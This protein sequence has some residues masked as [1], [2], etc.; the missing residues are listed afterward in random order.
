MWIVWGLRLRLI[1]CTWKYVQIKQNRGRQTKR[2]LVGAARKQ[3]RQATKPAHADNMW[4]ALEQRKWRPPATM[5]SSERHVALRGQAQQE[6]STTANYQSLH[7]RADLSEAKKVLPSDGEARVQKRVA[8][9]M[10]AEIIPPT[11]IAAMCARP[12]EERR[13]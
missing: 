8:V 11:A 10:V 6:L 2:Q 9:L 7:V 1:F 12:L 4:Q 13:G 5:Y 3:L